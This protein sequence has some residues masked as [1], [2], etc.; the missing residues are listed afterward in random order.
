[1]YEAGHVDSPSPAELTFGG[2]LGT[3]SSG[4]TVPTPSYDAQSMRCSNTYCHGNWKMRKANAASSNQ[5]VYTD[6]VIVGNNYAALWT[7]GSAEKACGTC[8]GLPPTGH[9]DFGSSVTVC[10]SCHYLN[11]QTKSGPL[12][13]SIHMNGK[14]DLFGQEY[15]FK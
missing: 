1:V 2:T 4:G 11:P 13:K 10:T 6:S 3:T 7:G 9:F 5:F 15:G 14:I 8:H 12:D